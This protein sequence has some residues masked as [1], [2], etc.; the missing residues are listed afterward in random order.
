MVWPINCIL[1]FVYCRSESNKIL[2]ALVIRSIIHAYHLFSL[3]LIT[4][5]IFAVYILLGGELVIHQVVV[6]YTL[7]VLV[8]FTLIATFSAVIDLAEVAVALQRIQV[9]HAKGYNSTY[10]EAN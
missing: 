7:I 8:R 10:E 5:L 6:A 9:H 3:P 2:L 1:L 4:F